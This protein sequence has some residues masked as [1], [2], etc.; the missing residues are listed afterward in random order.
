MGEGSVSSFDKV[1]DFFFGKGSTN[2]V[3]EGKD[4]DKDQ[5]HTNSKVDDSK[6]GL[7]KDKNKDAE[8]K[9]ISTAKINS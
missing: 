1:G 8:D 6:T 5:V 7:T 9:V 2:V 4:K 3:V